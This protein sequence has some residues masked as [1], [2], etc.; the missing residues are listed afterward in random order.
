MGLHIIP[1]GHKKV[2]FED[3]FVSVYDANG[4]EVYD[5]ILD[6][7]P[8]KDDFDEH[9]VW[10]ANNNRYK[11]PRDYVLVCWARIKQR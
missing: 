7:C 2:E 5:G 9:G 4:E 1:M 10:D 6:Y 11:L 3:D 8:F